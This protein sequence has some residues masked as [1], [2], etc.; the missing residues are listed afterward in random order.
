MQ[1]RKA[2]K[3]ICIWKDVEKARQRA[4]SRA[5]HTYHNEYQVQMQTLAEHPEVVDQHEVVHH[6]MQSDAPGLQ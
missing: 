4:S 1:S 6:Q 2:I 5:R 3:A